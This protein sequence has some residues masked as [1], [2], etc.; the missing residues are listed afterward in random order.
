MK[1]SHLQFSKRT[2]FGPVSVGL[3]IVMFAALAVT[4]PDFLTVQNIANINSQITALL[5]ATL[6]QLL[7]AL[8]GGI[9]LSVGSVISLVSAM[10]A[11]MDPAVA[12]PAVVAVGVGVGLVNGVGVA[13]FGVHPLI[14]TL[15]SMTFVQ[16]L[17]LLFL[18]GTGGNVSPWL[19]SLASDQFAGIPAA[20][21]W[22]LGAVGLV[23]IILYKTRF[24][25][26]LFAIGAN[27]QNTALSGV[28]VIIPQ[29][30]CYVMCSLS[31]VLASIY[32]T[33]RVASGD[34]RLGLPFGIDTVTAIA[35][36]GVQLTGGIGSVA[37][38]VLGT[39]TLGLMTNG[40]NFL[41][42]SPFFRTAI[43]GMLLLAAVSLQRRKAIGI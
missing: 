22:C 34:P 20:L 21:L 24:G 37:G 29:I 16:G 13:V 27:S 26:R 32:L 14:M 43:T 33:G 23:S 38:A 39:M 36:G 40:M 19:V 12:I 4:A 25:L 15:A 8:V 30:S 41:G 11:T 1:T 28:R 2:G 6:G 35:L 9:D 18:P 3:P 31:G 42:V 10:L 17:A 7:V 5:L